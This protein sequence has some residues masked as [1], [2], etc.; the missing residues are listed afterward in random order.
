MLGKDAWYIDNQV[1][2]QKTPS[3]DGVLCGTDETRT[4]DLR[5]DRPAF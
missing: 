4:R 1:I 3:L 5:L 2:K